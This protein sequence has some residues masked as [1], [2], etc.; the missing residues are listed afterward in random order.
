MVKDVWQIEEVT[1]VSPSKLTNI[2]TATMI[3]DVISALNPS[4]RK[5][6]PPDMSKKTATVQFWA[7]Y[8]IHTDTISDCDSLELFF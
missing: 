5:L 1:F 8:P 3:S 2:M 7:H 4:Y 6:N